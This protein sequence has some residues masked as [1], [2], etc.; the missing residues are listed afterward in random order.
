MILLKKEEVMK[1]ILCLLAVAV[2]G[3]AFAGADGA[4]L[5]KAKMCGACHAAGKKG[6]DLKDSKMDKASLVK[7]M[8]DPKSVNPKVTMPAVKATDE[9]L[10]ALADYVLSLRK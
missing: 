5:F 8:K 6:G 1:I 4:A 10:N 9:E 3:S 2:A 7:F